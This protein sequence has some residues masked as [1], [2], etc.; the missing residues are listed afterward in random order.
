MDNLR[1]GNFIAQRRKALGLTQKDLAQQLHVTDKA[2]SKWETGKG[3]PDLKLM[4]SLADALGVTLYELMEGQTADASPQNPYVELHAANQVVRQTVDYSRARKKKTK[5]Q[6]F[7][8]LLLL[9]VIVYLGC[10]TYDNFVPGKHYFASIPAEVYEADGSIS[11]EVKVVFHGKLKNCLLPFYMDDFVGTVSM[12]LPEME[13]GE[14]VYIWLSWTNNT[15]ETKTGDWILV[16]SGGMANDL[17]STMDEEVV[18]SKDM[19]NFAFSFKDGRI[20]ATTREMYDILS[21]EL[22]GQGDN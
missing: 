1:L 12:K 22:E 4:E 19:K 5:G 15:P 17:L 8:I 11:D 21:E 10:I 14:Q 3:F 18:F 16:T 7:G 20:V 13:T 9:L 2:V 6:K